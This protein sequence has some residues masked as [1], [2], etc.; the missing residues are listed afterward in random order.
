MTHDEIRDTVLRVV[1]EIAP[2]AD[3]AGLDPRADL[4]TA[5]DLDSVDFLNVV[6]G[7]HAALGIDVPEADY[8]KLAT[9]AGAVA[10][11]AGRLGRTAG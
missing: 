4:R 11:L 10:Y 6:L 8:P 5:L 1:G 2:E 3:L 9:L 7:L